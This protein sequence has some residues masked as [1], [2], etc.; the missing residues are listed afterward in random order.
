MPLSFD[1]ILQDYLEIQDKKPAEEET[2]YDEVRFSKIPEEF[3]STS[4]LP[5]PDSPR[6]QPGLDAEANDDMANGQ[7]AGHAHE[8]DKG[9]GEENTEFQL[10]TRR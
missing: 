3:L 8:S 9:E 4:E 6:A 7:V 5:I 1:A 2:S 10:S